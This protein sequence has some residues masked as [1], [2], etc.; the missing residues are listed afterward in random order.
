MRAHKRTLQHRT[1]ACIP[2]VDGVYVIRSAF[3]CRIV[4]YRAH[5]KEYHINYTLFFNELKSK[6]IELLEEVLNRHKI[7]KV[8]MEAFA[9]YTLPTKEISDVKSFNTPN[10]IVDQSMDLSS[11]WEKFVDLMINQTTEFQ[12]R[13]SGWALEQIMY[14]EVNVNKYSPMR[15][16]SFI[17]LPKFIENKK[18][19]VNIRNSDNCCFAWAVTS[20]LY[21]PHGRINQPTSYP[22]FSTV[23]NMTGID[24]PVKL[25]DISKFEDLNNISINVYGLESR[26]EDNRLKYEIVG[27]L[28]YSQKK[29]R[30]H[31]NLL[32]IFDECGRDHRCSND[33][34]NVHYC[35]IKDLSRLVSYQVSATK[36]KKYFCDGCLRNDCNHIYT[37]TPSTQP[38]IDKYGKEVP[39]NILKFENF[40]RQ[41]SVPFVVYADFESVLKPIQ[42]CDGNPNASYTNK[43]F[44]HEPY[45]FAY[46]VKCSFNESI[47][48]FRLYRGV[49]AAKTF[50]TSIESDVKDIYNRYLKDI[51]PMAKL[52][53]EEEQN[54]LNATTC[55]ICGGLFENNDT[56]VRDHCHLTGKVRFGAA[57]SVCNLNYKLPSFIPI[58][59]HNLSGYDSHLFIK[60]ICC[61]GVKVDVLAQNKEKYI[62]FTKHLYMH[63][64]INSKGEKRQKFLKLRFIDSFK[65]LS[66]SLQNLG[67]SLTSERFVETKRF[68]PNNDEFIIM[69]H[70]GV[71]PYSFV[72]SLEK[73][74]YPTLPS[75][76]QFYDK[77]NNVHIADEEY[78]RAKT[79]WNMFACRSLGEYS[80]LYLKTDV[81]L[82]CD[83]FENFRRICLDTYK[84]DPTHYYTAPG[85]SWDAMLKLTRIELELLTDIDMIHFLKKGI[86]GGISQCSERKHIAN[87]IFLP[88]FNPKEPT[89][90]IMYLDATNLYGHS[91]SQALP[92]NG[93]R[94][95]PTDE[96]ANL[97]VMSVSDDSKVGYILEVDVQ[98]P[99]ELHDLHADLPFLVESIIPPGSKSKLPKLIPNLNNKKQYVVHYRNLKQAID[100]GLILTKV[101]RVLTFS[102]LPWLKQ[103]IDLNTNM[104][105]KATSKFEKDQ[106]KLMNNAIFGKTMENVDNR[107]LIKLVTHWESIR[108]STGANALIAHPNFKT[109]SIFS[110]DFVAI[111]MGK[112]KVVYNKPIYL[113]FSILDLSKTVLYS[114]L[115]DIIKKQYGEKASLLYTDTDSLVLKV[116]TDNFYNYIMDNPDKFDTSNYESR[117]KFNIPKGVSV[118]GRMKDEFPADPIISFYGTGAKAYHIQSTGKELKKAKGVKKSVIEQQLSIDDYKQ[119]VES[120]GLIFRKMNSF[121]S[122]LHDMYTE[123]KNKVALSYHDDKR[124]MI[125]NTTKTLPWGA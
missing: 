80:D 32:L 56:K 15:G 88:N 92:T 55:G 50:V 19:V 42:T 24:F 94:W 33:C 10:E 36:K 27:P 120:G 48:K 14:L 118:L 124:F 26:F 74:D 58:I 112:L 39:E 99:Q 95:L 38:R 73:L 117:N 115:Y 125:P 75:K 46:L 31:V 78:E 123:L 17:N 82:L 34:S 20:A 97:D 77:L 1:N 66:T 29:L 45:S 84:L 72:D 60:E 40:E 91:M 53:P 41:M 44:L 12:E 13:D 63:D 103:Y 3:K 96:I 4:S 85:L 109:C 6:I 71:F 116:Y 83:V 110:E 69:R 25:K 81:L 23:L 16:S 70:K 114:F 54:F 79:V 104:R 107:R 62:S 61:H 28:R 89:S 119:I 43:T 68:F 108:R 18:A 64:Y 106:Y 47:T 102:Q 49:D 98:Y 37:T 105:N 86:R 5:S 90:Y 7:V 22:H 76:E 100:N 121:R 8:N 111:H 65:F 122:E 21:L 57:H 30:M 2:M 101:H 51:V 35:W 93:F 9:R 52:T 87:N 67:E 113:G 59:F 11:V